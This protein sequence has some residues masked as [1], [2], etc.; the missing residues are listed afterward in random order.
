MAPLSRTPLGDKSRAIFARR[1][2]GDGEEC[3]MTKVQ[4]TEADVRRTGPRKMDDRWW[5]MK[6]TGK[7]FPGP[8]PFAKSR[9]L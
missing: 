9:W 4:V 2:L 7:F 5:S 3:N 1:R 8:K 6:V